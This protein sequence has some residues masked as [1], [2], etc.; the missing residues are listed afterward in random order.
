MFFGPDAADR[1]YTPRYHLGG[2]DMKRLLFVLVLVGACLGGY[3][4]MTGKLPWVDLTPEEQQVA[5]LRNEFNQLRQQWKQAGR[6][7]TF[8]ADTS[9]MTDKP[10]EQL[11]QVEKDLEVLMSRLKTPAAKQQAAVLRMDI[12]SFKSEMR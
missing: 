11:E 3:Y 4:Y 10:V 12:A 2:V 5:E 1:V 9:T 6:A 8:G 7:A